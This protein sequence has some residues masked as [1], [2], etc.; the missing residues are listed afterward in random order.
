MPLLRTTLYM[1]LLLLALPTQA[2]FKKWVD[3]D[4]IVHYGTSIPPEYARQGHTE[5]NERGIEI[6]QVERAKTA[7]EIAQ[8]QELQRLRAEQARLEQEQRSRDRVLLKL[9]RGEEDLIMVRDGKLLQVDAQIK[10]K[11]KQ[12]DRLKERLSKLQGLAAEAERSGQPLHKKQ[13][14]NLD[15]VK[16]QIESGYG[17]LLDKEADKQ[18]ISNRYRRDLDRFRQL[19]RTQAGLIELETPQAPTVVQVPGVFVC[20]DAVHCARLWPRAKEYAMANA[21]TKVE[22]DGKRIFMTQRS[23]DPQEINLTLS[24]LSRHGVERI[25]LDV[26]CQDTLD[27]RALCRTKETQAIQHRFT[28]YLK[29]F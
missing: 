25:F 28:D 1:S 6:R 26:Q 14:E 23:S 19:Q 13:Q 11:L 15:A 10:L 8:E 29:Q 4:G 12:L 24:R 20:E 18:R 21:N 9:F 7:E 27:G 22:L 17:Y 16:L 3:A 2:A 5:I